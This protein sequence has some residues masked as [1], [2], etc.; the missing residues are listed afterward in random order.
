MH[1]QVRNNIRILRK[2]GY[3][4]PIAYQGCSPLS[5]PYLSGLLSYSS[6]MQGMQPDVCEG[7]NF[8]GRQANKRLLKLFG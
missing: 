2:S 7:M 6:G 8:V 4:G 1:V 5:C 3:D